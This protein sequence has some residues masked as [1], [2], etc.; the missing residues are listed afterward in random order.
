[1]DSK[2]ATKH[3]ANE[4]ELSDAALDQVA[5]GGVVLGDP[6]ALIA[7]ANQMLG[8]SITLASSAAQTVATAAV[9]YV[10]AG[11]AAVE[12]SINRALGIGTGS[13]PSGHVRRF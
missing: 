9:T 13:A 7:E 6:K 4:A 3:E 5:G 1:M 8:H 12:D 11:A 2:L 10:A